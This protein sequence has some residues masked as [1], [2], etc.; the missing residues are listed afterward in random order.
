[1]ILLGELSMWVALLMAAWA[2]LVS[3]AGGLLRRNE[4]VA[5]GERALLATFGLSALAAT[6]LCVALVRHDFSVR[7]VTEYVGSALPT[8]YSM[9][10]LWAGPAGSLLLWIVLH[11]GIASAAVYSS[12]RTAPTLIPYVTG[13]LSALALSWLIVLCFRDNPYARITWASAEGRGRSPQLQNALMALHPPLVY[14]GLLASGVPF[15]L[16]IGALVTR[17]IG[18]AWL[19]VVRR[20]ASISWFLL[21]VGMLVGMRWAYGETGW[22]GFWS[23]D[24]V[25]NAALLPWLVL[26]AYLHSAVLQERRGMMPRWNV[27]LL[28]LAFVLALLGDYLARSGI[29]PSVHAFAQSASS[30]WLLGV[31]VLMTAGTALLVGARLRFLQGGV[32]I[33]PGFNRETAL[34]TNNAV[35]M[36]V[37]A[38]TL[39]GT[40]LPVVSLAATGHRVVAA[41]AF[42]NAINVPLGLVMLLLMAVAPLLAWQRDDLARLRAPLGRALLVGAGSGI[43]FALAGVRSMEALGTFVLAG[44]ALAT[45]AQEVVTGVATR[46][47]LH[48]ESRLRAL[49]GLMAYHRRRHGGY[50]VHA[51]VALLFAGLAGQYFRTDLKANV[52]TGERLTQRDPYGHDWVFV[53]QGLSRFERP[54]YNVMAA[55]FAVLRDGKAMGLMTSEKRQYLDANGDP[56]FDARTVAVVQ[57]RVWQ[58]VR[59]VFAG[60][61][62]ADSADV[63]IAFNPLATWV[64]LGGALVALGGLVMMWPSARRVP[65]VATAARS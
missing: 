26:T 34:V 8:S 2:T 56:I 19:R 43:L 64:W 51:G 59:L 48:N 58:D 35:L 1:M 65:V 3:M 12:R 10:A 45:V 4:L 13:T 16:A 14:A 15:A 38:V 32:R 25:E 49:V 36:A 62:D 24:A 22:G 37:V 20:W 42:Y 27:L 5:S 44:M 7:Y 18:D 55:T 61:D 17:S 47:R 21:T 11:T 29:V 30:S 6:G 53:S 50:A 54:T 60:S 39:W 28:I 41:A 23:W 63:E 46:R 40:L 31:G 52:R 33:E 9:T 57:S